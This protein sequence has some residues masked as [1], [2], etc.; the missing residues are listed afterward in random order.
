MQVITAVTEFE[1]GLLVERTQSGSPLAKAQGKVP[2]RP[3]SVDAQAS[4]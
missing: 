3:R 2:G 1:R 4:K